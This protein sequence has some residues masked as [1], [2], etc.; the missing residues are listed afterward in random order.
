MLVSIIQKNA[1]RR[2]RAASYRSRKAVRASSLPNS[3]GASFRVGPR[4]C[5]AV[6]HALRQ[7]FLP[8]WHPGH[9]PH[10]QRRAAGAVGVRGKTRR[11]RFFAGAHRHSRPRGRRLARGTSGR[12]QR[13]GVLPAV[14]RPRRLQPGRRRAPLA[15]EPQ[16]HRPGRRRQDGARHD[17][18]RVLLATAAGR[19]SGPRALGS[20]IGAQ[21]GW[22]PRLPVRVSRLRSTGGIFAASGSSRSEMGTCN[23]Y[24]RC[25]GKADGACR[26]CLRCIANEGRTVHARNCAGC[27]AP[28]FTR[29]RAAGHLR[30]RR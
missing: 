21:P 7:L 16:L 2:S 30:G 13:D 23:Y 26:S 14:D 8:L 22:R 3:P 15:G 6:Q 25:L 9:S 17:G 28:A 20:P 4:L 18:R 29:S 11:V 24:S 1:A 27:F 19:V 5:F 10:Q 12:R